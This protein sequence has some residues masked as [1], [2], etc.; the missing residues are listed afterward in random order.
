MFYKPWLENLTTKFQNLIAANDAVFTSQRSEAETEPF[1]L[2][3]D[4]F[5][6]E[7]AEEFS[8][9][10]EKHNFKVTLQP[11]WSAIP[12]LTATA[13]PA[14]SPI[15]DEVNAS[16]NITEFRPQLSNGKDL[17]TPAFR[18]ALTAKGYKYISNAGQIIPEEK[19]WLEIGNI[20]TR[21]HEEQSGLVKRIEELFEQLYEVI[22]LAFEK[23][24]TSIKVVTDHGW[25]LLPGGLPKTQLNASLS[26]T[27]WGRCALIKEGVQTDLLHLPWRW[28][29]AIYI[30]YAPGISF[31]KANVEYAHGGI[32]IHE[33]LVPLMTIQSDAIQVIDAKIKEVKWVNLKCTITTENAP[34]NFTLS[35]RT[36]F[37][38]ATTS[39]IEPPNISEKHLSDNRCVLMVSEDFE[40]QA[41][42]VVLMD[43]TG[44]FIDKMLTTVGG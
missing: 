29:P 5:R 21:G 30:A 12:S 23:G 26:E 32:S 17:L 11:S 13:K 33:C 22:Y 3:V 15:S 31:F 16:S 9:R 4:A 1:I 38:D 39:I 2:F 40:S 41:V 14:A 7:M 19:Q 37:N 36:K 34:D 8:K 27:R 42:T 44:R 25:L 10:L 18:E 43:Q 20:D 24:V 35:I 28:N 6:F